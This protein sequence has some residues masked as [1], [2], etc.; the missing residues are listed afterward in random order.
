MDFY[1]PGVDLDDDDDIARKRAQLDKVGHFKM[2]F[3]EPQMEIK[4]FRPHVI[5]KSHSYNF[6]VR[7][8]EKVKIGKPTRHS[9]YLKRSRTSSKQ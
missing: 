1:D 5:R 7:G 2:G 4:I 8:R 3:L 6:D 9:N